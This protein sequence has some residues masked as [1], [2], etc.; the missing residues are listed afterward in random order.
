MSAEFEQLVAQF[1]R[2][3]SKLRNVDETFADLGQLRDEIAALETTAM[4]PDRSITVVAGPGG[5][6]KDVRFTESALKQPPQALSGALLSTLRQAVAE[7]AR[8]QA[9]IVES[10]VGDDM[11]LT[12]QVLQT[13]AQ[14][15]DTTPEELRASMADAQP[16]HEELHEDYSQQ[17]V[18]QSDE[19]EPPQPPPPPSSRSSQGEEFLQHLFDEEDRR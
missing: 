14:L 6:I 16:V 15:F 4:S 19:P 8:T 13:Q 11:H 12:D 9:G 17:S 18:L 10:H 2:F 7:A 3:Q 5:S 1:E